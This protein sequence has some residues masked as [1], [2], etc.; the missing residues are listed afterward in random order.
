MER[1]KKIYQFFNIT[2]LKSDMATSI[3]RYKF[4]VLSFILKFTSMMIDN[5]HY[6]MQTK[7]KD[8]VLLSDNQFKNTS[9]NIKDNL[10]T[11]E[12]KIEVFI[13]EIL[14]YE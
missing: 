9:E 10:F 11:H 1:M 7:Y 2:Q 5:I 14:H 3:L 8:N 4:V 6:Y 12:K 13:K